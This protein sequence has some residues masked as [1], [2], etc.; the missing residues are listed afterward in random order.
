[1]LLVPFP[2]S[3]ASPLSSPPSPSLLVSFPSSPPPFLSSFF[4]EVEVDSFITDIVKET[5][6]IDWTVIVDREKPPIYVSADHRSR[7]DDRKSV[8][9]KQS[10]RPT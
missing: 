7:I 10:K 3:S 9:F 5:N 8:K 2:S 6:G 4:G 1:M